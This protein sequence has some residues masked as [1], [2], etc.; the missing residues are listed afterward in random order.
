LAGVADPLAAEFGVDVKALELAM[1]VGAGDR[2]HA[3]A[4]GRL[5]FPL[6]EEEPALRRRVGAGQAGHLLVEILVRQVHAQPGRVIAEVL[7]DLFKLGS[8][9]SG[10]GAK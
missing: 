4:T 8:I 9:G 5:A 10:E 2:A 6:G 7:A 3:H 1:P